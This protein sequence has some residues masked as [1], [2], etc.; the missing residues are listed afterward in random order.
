M[1][2]NSGFKGLTE[3]VSLCNN[4]YFRHDNDNYE[5]QYSVA[6]R[7]VLQKN[8]TCCVIILLCLLWFEVLPVSFEY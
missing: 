2:F 6:S 8:P 5:D 7:A 3:F 4:H 1:G